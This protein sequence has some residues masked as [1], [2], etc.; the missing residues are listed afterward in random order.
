MATTFTTISKQSEGL[1]KDRGSKF[2]SFAFPV[3][4]EM[5]IKELI[6]NLRKKYHDA[7][8]HCYA[9]RLGLEP[10]SSRANDDGEPASSAGKPILN[11]IES[12]GLTN[13]LIVVVRYFGGTL[14]G[15]GGLINAYR[16]AA[17]DALRNNKLVVKH[18][19]RIYKLDFN[20][21]EINQVMKIIKEYDIESYNQKFEI[22]C[23]I[24]VIIDLEKEAELLAKFAL[25]KECNCTLQEEG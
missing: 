13:I 6:E 5:E 12:A 14:L 3:K 11:H 4:D 8:H 16:H 18:L 17:E 21:A 1:Y 20:Y 25:I 23:S 9:W 10:G 2:I 22:S 7:R 19:T 24:N 15:V